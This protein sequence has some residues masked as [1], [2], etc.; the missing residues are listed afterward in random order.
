MISSEPLPS[1]MPIPCFLV[2]NSIMTEIAEAKAATPPALEPV[3]FLKSLGPGLVTGAADDD[4][5]GIATYSQVGAQFGYGLAWTMLFSFPLMVVI[6][7]VAPVSAASPAA[8]SPRT[9]AGIIRR[10]CCGSSSC[11]CSS[12]MSSIS[13][14]IS[15]PWGRRSAC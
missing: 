7:E 4:P 15:A 12:P 14:P 2:Q 5:S 1:R 9:C 10:G 8:A 13:V 11:C 6:Q 3:G